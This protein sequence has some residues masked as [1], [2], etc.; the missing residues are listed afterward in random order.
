MAQVKK[1]KSKASARSP[2]KKTAPKKAASQSPLRTINVLIVDDNPDLLYSIQKGLTFNSTE[3]AVE[4]ANGGKKCLEMLKK[5]RPDIILLDIMMPDMDGWDTC[6]RIKSEKQTKDI[7]IVFL[8]AKTDPISKSMG[9]LASADYITKPFEIED[10]K[11]H[12]R[13]IVGGS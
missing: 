3:F 4:T 7:P 1:K 9:S 2:A 10:L 12:I 13:K 8:T 5:Y 11:A 6:A